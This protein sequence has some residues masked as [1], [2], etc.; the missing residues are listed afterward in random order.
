LVSYWPEL[1]LGIWVGNNDNSSMKWVTGITWAWYIYNQI[2]KKS[3][4]KW[5][6]T[7]LDY[8]LPDDLISFEYCWDFKC[9]R[10]E[11]S[12]K[13][14]PHNFESKILDNYYSQKDVFWDIDQYE[15]SR[16]E[17]LWIFLQE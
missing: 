14:F 11:I 15:K 2:I 9:Y 17:Q 5:I 12:Y 16:L 8:S 1:I 10:K 7:W 3:I 6:I 13:K 4:Q